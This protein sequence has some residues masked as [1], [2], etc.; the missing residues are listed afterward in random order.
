MYR[1]H[2]SV[3]ATSPSRFPLDMLRY[4]QCCPATGD[5]I[6]AISNSLPRPALVGVEVELIA[7]HSGKVANLTNARWQS[8]GWTIVP[9]TVKTLKV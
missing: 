8:F 1:T 2:F 7:Y 6:N 3:R 4:D 9:M 5:A